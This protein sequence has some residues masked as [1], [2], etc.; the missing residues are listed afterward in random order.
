MS[1][2]LLKFQR[3]AYEEACKAKQA[4]RAAEEAKREN[5]QLLEALRKKDET[6]KHTVQLMQTN[7]PEAAQLWQ[8]KTRKLPRME[9]VAIYRRKK[10]RAYSRQLAR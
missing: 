7:S 5:A 2:E 8:D 4:A 6:L 10:M 9:Q 1:Q 3:L